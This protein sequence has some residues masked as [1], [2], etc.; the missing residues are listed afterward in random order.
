MLTDAGGI[1]C[2]EPKAR[3][4]AGPP[5][6]RRALATTLCCLFPVI[7]AAAAPPALPGA[8]ADELPAIVV[9]APEPRYVAPTRFDRIGRIWVPAMIN[10]QGPFRL[11]LDT[12]ASQS[13][14]NAGVA[15]ALGI[16]LPGAPSVVL[17]GTTGSRTVA[18][19][20]VQS[21]VVGDLDLHDKQLP[22]IA[23]ALGGA[24]GIMGTEGLLD[25]RILI[26]FSHDRIAVQRSHGEAAPEGF[27]TVK[28]DV[29]DGLLVVA[30]AMVGRVPTRVIIDTGGQGTVANDALRSALRRRRPP[31]NASVSEIV[32]ATQDIQRGDRMVIPEM[33]LG[34]LRISPVE[35]TVGDFYIFRYWNMTQVP[36]LML[37]MDVIGLLDTLVIDYPRR[38]LQVRTH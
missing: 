34:G 30:D 28:V 22:V 31:D 21:I 24:E 14:V 6:A 35:V 8:T 17:S 10:G 37:G 26:D 29:V 36:T 3:A 18:A 20:S 5:R 9:S 27:V 19:I 16:P 2:A 23:D 4:R 1:A 13:A 38:E 7:G 25:K 15:E 32:G 12:G 11:V 33:L